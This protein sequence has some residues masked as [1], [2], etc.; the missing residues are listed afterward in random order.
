M[1]SSAEVVVEIVVESKGRYTTLKQYNIRRF[2]HC[3]EVK[4]AADGP[5]TLATDAGMAAALLAVPLN[6]T[7]DLC[8]LLQRDDDYILEGHLDCSR[9]LVF[10]SRDSPV[11]AKPLV[12]FRNFSGGMMA[13]L[14]QE[15][16][17]A[18]LCGRLAEEGYG[19]EFWGKVLDYYRIC[20]NQDL[21]FSAFGLMRAAASNPALAA[22]LFVLLF[23]FEEGFVEE[24][25]SRMEYDLGISFHWISKV[26][27]A[28]TIEWMGCY[29]D[30]SLLSLVSAGIR[31][32]FSEQYPALHFEAVCQY[33][34]TDIR[35]TIAAS[36]H[37]KAKVAL[38]RSMLGDRVLNQLPSKCPKIPEQYKELMPV[39][40]SNASV[41]ILLK[42]PVAV[43][44]SVVGLDDSLWAPDNDIVRRNVKY[45]QQLDPSWYSEA[46]CY[47]LHKIQIP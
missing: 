34:F 13:R 23:C 25:V 47:C 8:P 1:H 11:K 18:T 2:R 31:K 39:D 4:D 19:G 16:E 27:W 12:V 30:P 40:E 6:G 14:A 7:P 3:L 36:Y 26:N 28:E 38:L 24:S 33:I 43:A 9:F 29:T 35:P 45:S 37:L 42:S 22:R 20:R 32:Y 46:I 21:P 44:L 5:I 17:T 41:K 10:C 15:E